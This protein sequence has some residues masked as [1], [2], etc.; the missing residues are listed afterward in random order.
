MEGFW[1]VDTN[2]P[3]PL[4]LYVEPAI[5]GVVKLIDEPAQTGELLP[6]VGVEGSAFT[7]TVVVPAGEVQMPIVTETLYVPAI[8]AVTDVMTGF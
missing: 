3:G 8:V 2:P 5:V 7:T 6:A 4:Q 1:I